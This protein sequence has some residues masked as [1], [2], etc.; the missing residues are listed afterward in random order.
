M[1]KSSTKKGTVTFLVDIP[2]PVNEVI[3]ED[4]RRNNRKRK[5]HVRHLLSTYAEDISASSRFPERDAD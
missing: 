1:K 5:P 2:A 4:A 3:V